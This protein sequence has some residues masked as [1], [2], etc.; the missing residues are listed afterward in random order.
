[1]ERNFTDDLGRLTPEPRQAIILLLKE[2]ARFARQAL[3]P[4][5]AELPP[6]PAEDP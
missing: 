2:L 6:T 5:S 4:K 3:G 1:M